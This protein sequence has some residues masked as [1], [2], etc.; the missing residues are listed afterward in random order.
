LIANIL[1]LNKIKS[2][3]YFLNFLKN[4]THTAP[5]ITIHQLGGTGKFYQ[6]EKGDDIG[7]LYGE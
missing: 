3:F 7:H 2:L 6:K 1:F 4:N 5:H